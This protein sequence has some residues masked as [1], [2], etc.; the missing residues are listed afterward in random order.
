MHYILCQKAATMKR[1]FA[2]LLPL[3]LSISYA[4][5]K[6]DD[7][8]S[9]DGDGDG[10]GDGI[11]DG[12]GDYVVDPSGGSSGDGDGDTTELPPPYV[13]CT[14]N[15]METVGD[16]AN[17]VIFSNFDSG[18]GALSG[19]GMTGT[20]YEYHDETDPDTVTQSP[21]W[22]DAGGWLPEPGGLTSDGYALHAIGSGFS[23]WGSGQGAT[24]AWNDAEQ[25]NCLYDASAFDGITFWMRG[26]IVYDGGTAAEMDQGV[27][28]FGITE[29]DVVPVD[30][31]GNC[32]G[33]VG[34][35][36]DWHKARITLTE[37]WRRYSFRF[38]E[39][40]QDGWGASDP[41]LEMDKMLNFNFEVA[42]GHSYDFWLDEVEFFVGDTPEEE[43]ICEEGGMGG[44]GG[45]GGGGN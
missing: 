2:Y 14:L 17:G 24:P 43:E 40:T 32:T 11:G 30:Q 15:G 8:G 35:C 31:G 1:P 27:L 41:E 28:K 23:E 34:Q 16:P 26:S 25:R 19:N 45:A 39:L 42:Q 3:T 20:W 33:D 36:W 37:C 38:D 5:G 7:R 22:N 9:G 4:C 10:D 12:D 44:A 13:S 6:S 29:P 18:D 21:T